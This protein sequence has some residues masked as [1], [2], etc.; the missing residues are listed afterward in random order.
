[1]LQSEFEGCNAIYPIVSDFV[2]RPIAWGTY[3]S[4]SNTHYYVAEFVP[5]IEEVPEPQSF[6]ALLAK[7]HKDSIALSKNGKFGFHVTTYGGTMPND[8]TW[9]DTWEEFFTRGLRSF[10]EQEK[11]AQGVSEELEKCF[12]ESSTKSSHDCL[13]RLPPKDGQSNR[14]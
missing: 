5:K 10:A 8:V 6:C 2:P 4:D 7:L 14:Y 9:C 3:K 12:H 11:A 13:D 1:M